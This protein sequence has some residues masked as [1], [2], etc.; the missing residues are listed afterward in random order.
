MEIAGQGVKYRSFLA[1]WWGG[2]A[3]FAFDEGDF[4]SLVA[5]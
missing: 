4:A 3:F 5:F 2:G 1:L